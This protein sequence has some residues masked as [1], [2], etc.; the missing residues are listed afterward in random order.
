M[1]KG[2]KTTVT[3]RKPALIAGIF[4]VVVSM[5]WIS[6]YARGVDHGDEALVFSIVYPFM[7]LTGALYGLWIAK[8]WGGFKSALGRSINLFA[9]GLLFQYL[10]QITYIYYIFVRGIDVPYPSWGDVGYF[11]SVLLYLAGALSLIQA[12]FSKLSLATGKDKVQAIIIPLIILTGSYVLFLREYEVDLSTPF[13]TFLDFGYPLLQ[14]LY[15]SVAL[16]VYLLSRNFLGGIIRMPIL[17]LVIALGVQYFADFMF[18]FQA[19]L[20]TWQILGPNEYLYLVSY[21]AMTFALLLLG[22]A[23]QRFKQS[24]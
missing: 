3:T 12:T 24:K 1:F 11:G 4:F 17:S 9:L 16:G 6:I 10:G 5:W 13:K 22:V 20:G 2:L 21:A 15:I 8:K 18:L 7:A 19:N 14:A 23:L